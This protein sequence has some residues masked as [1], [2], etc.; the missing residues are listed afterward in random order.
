MWHCRSIEL[1]AR[2]ETQA[3][4]EHS[5]SAQQCHSKVMVQELLAAYFAKMGGIPKKGTRKSGGP[6]F[7]FTEYKESISAMSLDPSE[8]NEMANGW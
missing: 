3:L 1:F 7:C 2:L 4:S 5:A 8:R 6:K